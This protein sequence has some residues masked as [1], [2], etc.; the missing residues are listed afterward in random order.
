MQCTG[1]LDALYPLAFSTLSKLC[2]RA[3]RVPTAC[4]VEDPILLD[5]ALPLHQTHYSDIYQGR[6]KAAPVALKA[7]RI[8][9]DDRDAVIQVT[10]LT[11]FAGSNHN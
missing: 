6:L 7:L 3:F 4:F 8:H 10:I 9:G 1:P 11:A 2:R 5:H